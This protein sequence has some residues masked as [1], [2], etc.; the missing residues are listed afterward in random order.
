MIIDKETFTELAVHLKKV[1]DGVLKTAHCMANMSSNVAQDDQQWK[2]TVE[3]MMVVNSNVIIM[4]QLLRAVL[5]A[6]SD[7]NTGPPEPC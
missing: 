6:N 3:G 4:E 7:V 1:S 5:D 2:G